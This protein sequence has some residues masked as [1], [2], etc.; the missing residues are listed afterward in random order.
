VM[1]AVMKLLGYTRTF[2]R[3]ADLASKS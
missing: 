2:E 3:T 1:P